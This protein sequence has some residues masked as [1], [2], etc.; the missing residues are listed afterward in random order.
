MKLND[1]SVCSS[2]YVDTFYIDGKYFC[3]CEDCGIRTQSYDSEEEAQQAWN[4]LGK[5]SKPINKKLKLKYI[6]LN[7][8]V[9]EPKK[10][11]E[12]AACY[13]LAC[14]VDTEIEVKNGIYIVPLGL[15][16]SIP[17]GYHAKIYPRSSM[18]LR[19]K[20]TVANSVGIIDSGY[21]NEWKLLIEPIDWTSNDVLTFGAACLKGVT[22]AQV[23]FVKNGLDVEFEP[24]DDFGDSYNRGGGFGSTG[25]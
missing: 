23:E 19:Y 7:P 13:D 22:L 2:R 8:N 15:A 4:S 9:V 14:P 18:P 16:I 24:V 17:E 21:L 3:S 5:F 12:R 6:A 10:G 11:D 20:A 1:C 25:N